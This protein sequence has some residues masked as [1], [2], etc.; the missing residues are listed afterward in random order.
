MSNLKLSLRE[1]RYAGSA[2]LPQ[3]LGQ[4]L[5]EAESIGRGDLNHALNLQSHVDA[6]LGEIL[7]SEGLAERGQVLSALSRQHNAQLADLDADPPD[8]RLAALL[9]SSL[10]LEH[11]VVPWM[12][13]G[14]SIVAFTEFN[15]MLR[16]CATAAMPAVR[17]PARPTSTNSTG[18][19]PLSS[20][21]K[22][23]G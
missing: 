9:P 15:W 7:I 6:P 16:F 5:L 11:G 4:I 8:G 10:C 18:V 19:D 13:I 17:Q 23:S 14:A 3:P 20:D 12:S 2:P 1:P 22:I 21:A